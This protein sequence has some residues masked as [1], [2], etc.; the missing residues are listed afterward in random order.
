M[1]AVTAEDIRTVAERVRAADQVVAPYER[2]EPYDFEVFEPLMKMLPEERVPFHPPPRRSD[3]TDRQYH[4][5]WRNHLNAWNLQSIND[6]FKVKGG[7]L[8]SP[9]SDIDDDDDVRAHQALRDQE[10]VLR[11]MN[12][13]DWE[14]FRKPVVP[15]TYGI[16]PEFWER[17]LR[18]T[19]GEDLKDIISEV[20][21]A[22]GSENGDMAPSSS[23]P[24]TAGLYSRTISSSID[25]G[26]GSAAE[27][28]EVDGSVLYPSIEQSLEKP[29]SGNEMKTSR[30]SSLQNAEPAQ[31]RKR[32]SLPVEDDALE[33]PSKKQMTDKQS[34]L[35]TALNTAGSKRKRDGGEVLD[36]LSSTDKP[37]RPSDKRRRLDTGRETQS[38]QKRKRSSQ[39]DDEE[40]DVAQ[41]GYEVPETK[42]RRVNKTEV[43]DAKQSAQDVSSAAG[44]ERTLATVPSLRM[45]RARRQQLSCEDAQLLQLDQRGKPDVQEPKQAAQELVREL[46]AA[47][48]NGRRPK[49]AA[50]TDAKNSRKTKTA[51]ATKAGMK[52]STTA[53]TT[54][55]TTTKTITKT[56]SRNTSSKTRGKD[57]LSST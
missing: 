40:L 9:S 55:K 43:V 50:S 16:P 57:W 41:L 5:V 19:H 26:A 29:Q 4:V 30:L 35:S 11:G 15:E 24:Q 17:L 8:L 52:A 37:A 45:T 6:Y 25:Y 49:K 48:R 44:S 10:K 21:G 1:A 33:R 23:T 36:E 28:Q 31:T 34:P 46:P 56:R 12:I 38:S 18:R 47:S 39:G 54:S 53:N 20:I 42:R 3:Q 27:Q 51:N 14:Y 2:R 22:S 13:V 7:R 32:R